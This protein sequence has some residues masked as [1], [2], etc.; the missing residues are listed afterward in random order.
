MPTYH[1]S[2]KGST[3][4]QI[5]QSHPVSPKSQQEQPQR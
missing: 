3:L 4:S 1:K 2:A 5:Y